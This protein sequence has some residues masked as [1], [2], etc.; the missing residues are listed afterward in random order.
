MSIEGTLKTVIWTQLS[1][2]IEKDYGIVLP[3]KAGKHTTDLIS[4]IAKVQ[5]EHIGVVD[6]GKD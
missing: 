5:V 6:I 1:Q 2:A 4:D 3:Q